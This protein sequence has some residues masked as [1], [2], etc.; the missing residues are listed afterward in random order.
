MKS[1]RVTAVEVL[2]ITIFAL[3]TSSIDSIVDIALTSIGL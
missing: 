3:L 2:V 1:D